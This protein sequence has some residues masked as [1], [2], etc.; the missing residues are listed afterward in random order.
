ME[1]CGPGH[2]YASGQ[3]RGA[4]SSGRVSPVVAFAHNLRT[5][6]AIVSPTRGRRVNWSIEALGMPNTDTLTHPPLELVVCQVRHEPRPD[7]VNPTTVL[8]MREALGFGFDKLEAVRPGVILT[9]GPDGAMVPQAGQAEGWRLVTSDGAWIATFGPDSFALECTRYTT[10]SEFSLRLTKIAEVA[11]AS[12]HPQ[13]VQR[14]GVRYVDRIWRADSTVPKEWVDLLDPG[15]LGFASHLQLGEFVRV[16]QT[17]QELVFG[18]YGANIRGSIA[19]DQTPS[20]HSFLL[21]IDCFDERAAAYD[22]APLLDV[23]E[24]LHLLNLRLFQIV[25]ADTLYR[26]LRG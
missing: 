6:H 8:A 7:G 15:V 3:V 14:I 22:E 10:W 17:N 23:V 4:T 16:T 11:T 26:E 21:D 20:K 12:Y 25:L 5:T 13:L 1:T 18:E 9:T 19:S 24:R 2:A